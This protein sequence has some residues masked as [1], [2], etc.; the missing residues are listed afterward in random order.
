MTNK[1]IDLRGVPCPVNYVRCSLALEKLDSH[2]ILQVDIDRGEPEETIISG[3]SELG[4]NIE[5][6][7]KD[8]SF[9][10]ILIN[11]FES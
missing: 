2:E 11:R 4:H 3:L 6:L 8:K 1:Y 10:T 9:M 5:V 7:S